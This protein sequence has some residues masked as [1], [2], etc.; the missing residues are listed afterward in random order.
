LLLKAAYYAAP[1]DAGAGAE[2][3]TTAGKQTVPIIMLHEH[4]SSRN[5]FDVLAKSFQSKGYSV[6]V[7][8]LRGHGESTKFVNSSRRD[9]EAAKL[10]PLDFV[11]MLQYDLP[12]LRKFL[13]EKNDAGE[14]NLNRLC[15]VGAEMGAVLAVNW[16]AEDWSWPD[17]PVAKQGRD[18]KALILISPEWAFKGMRISNALGQRTLKSDRISFLMLVGRRNSKALASAK[19]IYKSLAPFHLHAERDEADDLKKHTLFLAEIETSLQG[20]K[21]LAVPGVNLSGDL[22]EFF[23]QRAAEPDFDWS[24]RRRGG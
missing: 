13:V 4:K 12:A 16:T 5:V 19:R 11:D 24:V 21:L 1:D 18:V 9:L 22:A 17:L 14:L 6:L 3:D 15:L 20:T 7:P 10:R 8:D 23:K 2:S